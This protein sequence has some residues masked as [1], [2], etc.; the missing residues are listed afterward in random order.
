MKRKLLSLA[1]ALALCLG[2]T[3]FALAEDGRIHTYQSEA[4]EITNMYSIDEDWDGGGPGRGASGIAPMKITVRRDL[5]SFYITTPVFAEDGS[6]EEKDYKKIES[7]KAGDTLTLEEPG[8]YFISLSWDGSQWG[9]GATD[10]IAVTLYDSIE[11]LQN[12]ISQST[13]SEEPEAAFTDVPAD[14]YY[15]APVKWAVEQ[16][17][18]T[19]TT[20]TTFSPNNTCSK[21]QILTF[22][23]RANGSP[24]STVANPFTDVE[25]GS[26]FCKAAL[27]AAEK[28]IVSGTSFEANTPCTRAMTVEYMWKA[29]GSPKASYDGKFG[30]VAKDADFAQAVAWALDSG[31]TSGTTDTT[32]SPANT[33]TRGQIVTFLYRALAE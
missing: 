5:D 29:A 22:L 2:L 31:V 23:Y 9:I 27:W 33:C 10:F 17:I 13:P 19:G 21:A 11:S 3:P 26:Y 18:T 4:L 7:P 16:G 25:E 24:E 8:D 32:F 20:D 28:G 14:A 6:Y 1:L 30:D 15:A 12:I